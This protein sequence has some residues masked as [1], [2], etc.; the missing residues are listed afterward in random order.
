MSFMKLR[1][2]T[3][4]YISVDGMLYRIVQDHSTDALLSSGAHVFKVAK[5]H[6]PE[7]L[8]KFY[9]LKDLW[10]EK[11]RKLEHL[12]YIE[13][14]KDVQQLYSAN[15]AEKVKK[16]MLTPISNTFVTVHVH[17]TKDETETSMLQCWK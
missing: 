10:P 4:Y 11:D 16:H 2:R 12:V 14:L 3:F 9:V 15:D 1:G 6:N 8:G 17:D 13:M 7:G 5:V